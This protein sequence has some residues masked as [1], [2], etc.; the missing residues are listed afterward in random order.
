MKTSRP[1][2]VN[3]REP[4][5]RMK[6]RAQSR[7]T[8]SGQLSAHPGRQLGAH[9]SSLSLSSPLARNIRVARAP[10]A[11]IGDAG[12]WHLPSGKPLAEFALR[13]GFLAP[14]LLAPQAHG[15]RLNSPAKSVGKSEQ[16]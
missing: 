14:L 12:A 5:D 3:Y 9:A 4:I 6:E 15:R 8:T 2:E 10:V 7:A 13:V 1:V 16:A 11:R